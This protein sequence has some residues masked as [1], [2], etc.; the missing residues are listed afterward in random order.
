MGQKRKSRVS[1]HGIAGLLKNLGGSEILAVKTEIGD[2]NKISDLPPT[3]Q[4]DTPADD[5]PPLPSPSTSELGFV[6]SQ[7]RPGEAD[8]IEAHIPTP[9][10]TAATHIPTTQTEEPSQS[11]T[12]RERPAKR[13]KVVHAATNASASKWAEKYGK[14]WVDKYDASGLVPYYKNKAEVPEE[15]AKCACI[16]LIADEVNSDRAEQ[17]S[18]SASGTSLYI[19]NRQAVFWTRKAGSASRRKRLRT[20]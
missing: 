12:T 2:R 11:T 16:I 4:E 5:L 6:D 3:K 1:V 18:P 7:R 14:A 15:L 10:P 17:T 13:Q 19:P 8:A 20:G 9:R